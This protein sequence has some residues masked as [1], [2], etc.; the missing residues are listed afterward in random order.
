MS[1]LCGLAEL[2]ATVRRWPGVS[3]RTTKTQIILSREGTNFCWLSPG[4]GMVQIAPPLGRSNVTRRLERQ[5]AHVKVIRQRTD[6][7]DA[8]YDDPGSCLEPR[9][10][11]PGFMCS[12]TPQSE[13]ESLVRQ[14]YEQAPSNSSAT[15]RS[16]P[17]APSRR[18][19]KSGDPSFSNKVIQVPMEKELV[20]AL[21]SWSQKLG[22][23]R[24]EIIREACR[25]YLKR[26]ERE[27]LDRAYKAGYDRIPEE[28]TMALTQAALLGQVLPKEEW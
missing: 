2:E 16:T 20:Q 21:D 6:G 4:N 7:I 19:N 25:R 27:E 9:F 10:S 26:L 5:G 15:V 8:E 22:W 11:Y 13:A 14:A 17:H 28:P 3:R 1:K 12:R 18:G 24:A 23:S